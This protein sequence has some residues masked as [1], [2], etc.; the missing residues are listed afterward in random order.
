MSKEP[1]LCGLAKY[2]AFKGPFLPACVIH[3]KDY[4]RVLKM[5]MSVDE[6]DAR[7]LRNLKR[8]NK[9]IVRGQPFY[10]RLARTF[11]VYFMYS[12]AKLYGFLTV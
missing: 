4:D 9:V 5:Q 1:E 3:D 12:V 2:W 8:I 10:V 11:Q 6:A 7:L